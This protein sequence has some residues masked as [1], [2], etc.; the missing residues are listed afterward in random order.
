MEMRGNM[1][2]V[3]LNIESLTETQRIFFQKAQELQ[4]LTST[5]DTT[6]A[7]TEWQSPAA[8]AFR[9]Q[10]AQTFLPALRNVFAG[11]DTFQGEM[12]KQLERYRINE[13]L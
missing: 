13:G 3:N 4:A 2:N 12:L 5:V 9:Q 7:G 11:L 10:W 8:E 6:L 1:P